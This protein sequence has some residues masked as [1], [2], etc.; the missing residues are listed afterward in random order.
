MRASRVLTQEEYD[1]V[2]S[3][4]QINKI[5]LENTVLNEKLG[6]EKREWKEEQNKKEKREVELEILEKQLEGEEVELLDEEEKGRKIE[7][8]L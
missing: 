4:D 3:E 8:R 5:L 6:E 2:K 1:V 7:R